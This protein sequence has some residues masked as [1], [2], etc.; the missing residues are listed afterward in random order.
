[1]FIAY[2]SENLRR[3]LEERNSTLQELP[4]LRFRSSKPRYILGSS[5]AINIPL[6]TECP[7]ARTYPVVVERT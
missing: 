1:M 3:G 5:Q 7:L 2:S 6:L 4:Q